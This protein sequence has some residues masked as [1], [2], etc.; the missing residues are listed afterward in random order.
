MGLTRLALSNPVAVV[1]A[2]LLLLLV[3]AIGLVNLPIQ[4]IPDVQRPFIQITTGW[5]SA[6]PEEVESEIIEPQEDMLRGI[7][8]LEKIE[9][10]AS[11]G[12][13]S[14]NLMFSVDTDIQR[15]LLEVVNRLNQVPR[16]PNDVT[17]PRIFAGQDSFGEQ[18]AWF[19]LTQVPG[20]TRPMASYNDF[21]REVVQA[22][23]ER[24]PGI[25]NSNSYGGRDNEV[26]IT[27]D[28]YEAAALGIDIPTLSGLTGN[29]NDTS[30]GFSDVGRRQYTLRYAGKY[31]VPDFGE[32]VLDWRGGNPVRLRDIATV[33]VTMRDRAGV[34][35]ES[36]HDAIAFDAQVERGVNVLEVMEGLKAAIAELQEGALKREGLVVQQVYDE[37]T[38]IEAAIAMLRTNLLLG[39]GLA[40]TVL[41]WFMRKMRATF[42]VALAIPVSLFT[43]FAVMQITG[44]T[45]N[46]ISLAGL[47]FATGMVLDAAIVV[48]E[49]IVRLREKGKESE[50]AAVTGSQQVWGALIASTATTVVIF[51]PIAFLKDVSGQLFADLAIVI[52]V[53][54][55]ASL[56]IAVTIIPT[57]A[58]RWLKDVRLDDPHKDWWDRIT[59]KI[60]QLTDGVWLRRAWVA[61]LVSAATVLTWALLP[62]ADYLPEGKQGWV[63]AFILPPPGQSVTA[64]KNEFVDVVVDRLDPYLEE[65]SDLQ[66][67]SYFLGVFGSFGFTGAKVTDTDE[68]GAF[69]DK[70]NTEVLT[71]FPDTMAF[72]DEWGIFDRLSGGSYIDLNIQSRDMDAMLAAARQGM[73]LVAQHLPGAQARPV[74]GIDFSE[75]ELRFIPNERRITEAGWTR[76]QM[77]VVM[78]AL[79]DGVF[80]D[81][82][83]D[84]DRRLD[85]VL[86]APEWTSPEQ[87]ASTPLATPLG[88]IQPVGQLVRM[89]RTAGP[90]QVRRVDRR[91]AVTLAIT[92]PDDKSLEESIEILQQNVEPALLSMLPEDG[93]VSYYGSADDLKIALGSMSRSFALAIVVLY[94]LMSGLFR[95]FID[96]L[97][98]I[99]ALPLATIG[100]VT[101]LR[102]M[103][104]P[105]NLLTMIGFITLLGLVVN[106]AIL[107]VHQTRSAERRGFERRAAVEQAIRRRLRPILM[108]TLTSLFGMLPLLLIPGPGTEV[109]QGLAAVIVGGMS[110][111]TIFTLILLPSLLRLGEGVPVTTLAPSGARASS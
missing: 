70:L 11:R 82:Y 56:I 34:M 94:L 45:L 81:D 21:V 64:A 93:E 79:G 90:S 101:L 104:L 76:Q 92:P 3:G 98:V 91:R 5:R 106:N 65:D 85:I 12:R 14:V 6:A 53:A 77:S 35:V 100:G 69:V 75:P 47:A 54:V 102:L 17:E 109:Y 74:P 44:R 13:A 27:F 62:P 52:S 20:N 37:S 88:G 16:Y 86:R 89:E 50:Q 40:V 78:R 96:S 71:G 1:A 8:G 18:I 66:V 9:S 68:A 84:G 22:R 25:S 10:S 26:R 19:A 36:G 110:V 111:S 103:N 73:G 4:M 7:P 61:G 33:E 55:V 43:G 83:F 59:A 51:L 72:A 42:M 29:N 28:P 105:M 97:L 30:G 38:Y 60:M 108:S 49:N 107:L 32:M 39:I 2:I 63:F 80:V 57:A 46:M 58:A 99:T 31:D 23:I 24:V 87:L 67:D 41:W 48:L 15:A 95:S